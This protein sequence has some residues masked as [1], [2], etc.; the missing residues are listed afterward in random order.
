MAEGSPVT[1]PLSRPLLGREASSPPRTASPASPAT[2][3]RR[4]RG[5][6]ASAAVAIAAILGVA[7]VASPAL[8]SNGLW[9][10][11]PPYDDVTLLSRS[12]RVLVTKLRAL[13][14]SGHYL[15]CNATHLR[16]RHGAYVG[17]L[18]SDPSRLA[19][20]LRKLPSTPGAIKGNRFVELIVEDAPCWGVSG[21]CHTNLYLRPDDAVGLAAFAAAF[22]HHETAV[23]YSLFAASPPKYVLECGAGAGYVTALFKALWPRA[24]VVAVEHDPGNYE[25]MVLN[26][27]E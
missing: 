26:T 22:Q 2:R 27:R 15:A 14:D 11:S 19:P 21:C 13:A 16:P 10:L 3:R 20:R 6:A 18:P 23:L 8:R 17:R 4:A 12:D 25:A 7:F 5:V 1:P 24:V 9:P